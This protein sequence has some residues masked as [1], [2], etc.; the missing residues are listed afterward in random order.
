VFSINDVD[1]SRL[2]ASPIVSFPKYLLECYCLV[3]G[4]LF[5]L[6][7]ALICLLHHGIRPPLSSLSA[8]RFCFKI[9]LVEVTPFLF[10]IYLLQIPLCGCSSFHFDALSQCQY[11]LFESWTVR[12]RNLLESL[13]FSAFRLFEEFVPFAS[14]WSFTSWQ[15]A[16]ELVALGW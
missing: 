10:Q 8:C 12:G 5:S 3:A 16:L 14:S 1:D 4:F 7:D 11:S 15:K 2:R 9:L 6:G 13:S